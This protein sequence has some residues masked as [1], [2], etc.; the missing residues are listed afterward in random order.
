MQNHDLLFTQFSVFL[1]L[2]QVVFALE[3]KVPSERG[4]R[5][6]VTRPHL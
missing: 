6:E 4:S 3:Q 1:A 5:H 2:L